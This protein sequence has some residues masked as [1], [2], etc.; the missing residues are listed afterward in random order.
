M[1]REIALDKPAKLVD[2]NDNNNDSGAPKDNNDGLLKQVLQEG[3][4]LSSSKKGNFSK[5]IELADA[6]G[7]PSL[8][9]VNDTLGR[10]SSYTPSLTLDGSEQPKAKGG[11]LRRALEK[12]KEGDGNGSP[13][14]REDGSKWD[15]GPVEIDGL[16]KEEPT[17]DATEKQKKLIRYF[18]PIEIK[19]SGILDGSIPGG[20]TDVEGAKKIFLEEYKKHGATSGQ[21]KGAERYINHLVKQNHLKKEYSE[22]S[23]EKVGYVNDKKL[24][25]CIREFTKTVTT[26]RKGEAAKLTDREVNKKL[27]GL[28]RL[29]SKPELYVGQGG[30]GS[31]GIH[32]GVTY[33]CR[34]APDQVARNDRKVL[35]T[36]IFRGKFSRAEMGGSRGAFGQSET[37]HRVGNELVRCVYNVA[38]LTPSYGGTDSDSLNKG[39]RRFTHNTAHAVW[40]D[41]STVRNNGDL[42]IT[43][44]GA[45]CQVSITRA[46]VKDGMIYIEEKQDNTWDGYADGR[47]H[48]KGKGVSYGGSGTRT[49]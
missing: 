27:Y 23:G 21:L 2:S 47:W 34:K 43:M 8:S 15:G 46:V 41:G 6:S 37:S 44:G 18:K 24:T 26:Q 38:R 45:H 48:R 10:L 3:K 14:T 22:K 19:I 28:I 5:D 39:I 20:A 7:K 4:G 29:I 9:Y 1:S 30:V 25:N 49:G 42:D 35:T 36:G 17:P 13:E 11:L 31:C 33:L 16:G 12:N 40:N 32:A